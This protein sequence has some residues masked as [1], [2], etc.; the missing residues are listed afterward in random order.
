MANCIADL[1]PTPSPGQKGPL[2][3]DGSAIPR[4]KRKAR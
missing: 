3:D 2:M 1:M 4:L